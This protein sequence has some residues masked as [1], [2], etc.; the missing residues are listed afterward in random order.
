MDDFGRK[1][2]ALVAILLALLMLWLGAMVLLPFL[3]ALLWSTVLAVLLYPLHL[4]FQRKLNATF[5]A[6]ATTLVAIIVILIP[7]TVAG[8]VVYA[9]ANAMLKQVRESQPNGD[10]L[11]I[12][13]LIKS[14]DAS[15]APILQ[16][17]GAGDVNLV[18]RFEENRETI[19]NNLARASGP[20]AVKFAES[21]V[22]VVVA[23]L[24]L[25]FLLRDGHRLWEPAMEIIPLPAEQSET[26]LIRMRDTIFA[27]FVGV[28]LVGVIQA[29]LAGL[30]YWIAGVPNAFLWYVVTVL[31]CLV[32]L[33]GS[34]LVYVPL[35]VSLL[36]TGHTWQ[37]VFLLL[38]GFIVVS[39]IDN[40]LRPFFIGLRV[41]LHPMAIFFS[42]L[43]GLF[44]FGPVGLMVGPLLLTGLLAL[45]EVVRQRLALDRERLESPRIQ[46][47]DP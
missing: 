44:T 10:A 35:S 21:A 11:T 14:A 17:L 45:L 30:G 41:P 43:G 40:L 26:I 5:S 37:G 12:D 13:A 15:L 47:N 3:P 2:R 27:V 39:Q 36:A 38:W 19:A 46:M 33:L 20:L 25:F 32:P 23:F 16:S 31:L 22:L 24:T 8:V 42:L 9:Q 28:M 1:Y 6:L 29:T 4:R 34:P 18:Q 7:V